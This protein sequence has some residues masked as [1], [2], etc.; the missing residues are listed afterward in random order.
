MSSSQLQATV[1][2][3]RAVRWQDH[4]QGQR[5]MNACVPLDEL[6][7]TLTQFRAQTLGLALPT[8]TL[9]FIATGDW[10]LVTHTH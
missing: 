10:L 3:R 5:E 4:G 9:V 8:F 6:D 2:R 1:Y 7:S